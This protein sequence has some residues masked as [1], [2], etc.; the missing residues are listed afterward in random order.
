MQLLVLHSELAKGYMLF[1]FTLY[2]SDPNSNIQFWPKRIPSL[3]GID[4]SIEQFLIIYSQLSRKTKKNVHFERIRVV[5]QIQLLKQ[6]F[7]DQNI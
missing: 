5:Q 2:T 7:I 1:T 4:I 3:S 6:C